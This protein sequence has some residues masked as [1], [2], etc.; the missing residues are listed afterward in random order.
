LFFV[1]ISAHQW[2]WHSIF[3]GGPGKDRGKVEEEAEVGEEVGGVA[4]E[5]EG[6]EVDLLCSEVGEEGDEW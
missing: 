1:R 5:G 2:P 6:E 3:G 4:L